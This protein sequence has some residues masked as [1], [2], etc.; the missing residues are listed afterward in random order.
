ML[1]RE[2][3]IENIKRVK[4]LHDEKDPYWKG[5]IDGLISDL[6]NYE[7]Q[8]EWIKR[9]TNATE[10]DRIWNKIIKDFFGDM[11]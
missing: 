7:A 3:I 11:F 9:S 5:V 10:F 4:K 1:Y 8:K 6:K 2:I